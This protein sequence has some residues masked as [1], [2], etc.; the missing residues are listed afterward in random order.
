MRINLLLA[1]LITFCC[2]S[3]P[4]HGQ[5]LTPEEKNLFALVNATSFDLLGP[6]VLYSVPGYSATTDGSVS[7]NGWQASLSGR[8]V[9]VPVSLVYSGAYDPVM[10]VVRWS[11]TGSFGDA[12]WTVFGTASFTAGGQAVWDSTALI[13]PDGA[14]ASSGPD[15]DRIKTEGFFNFGVRDGSLFWKIGDPS[16]VITD[17]RGPAPPKEDPIEGDGEAPRNPKPKPEPDDFIEDLKRIKQGH[18]DYQQ[19]AFGGINP[20]HI[21]NIGACIPEPSTLALFGAGTC[22][23][24]GCCWRRR[25]TA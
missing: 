6:L 1:L 12:A 8:Y 15:R 7:A 14:V 5:V 19:K 10:D 18:V 23:L 11:G 4:V 25:K 21:E 24:A 2:V 20:L 16:R 22:V 9:D 3:R 17:P 13:G